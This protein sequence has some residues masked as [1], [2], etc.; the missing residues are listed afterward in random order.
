ME[1]FDDSL[2]P[3]TEALQSW[4]GIDGA[5]TPLGGCALSSLPLGAVDDMEGVAASSTGEGLPTYRATS[6]SAGRVPGLPSPSYDDKF[7]RSPASGKTNGFV[8]A[9]MTMS[10]QEPSLLSAEQQALEDLLME[11]AIDDAMRLHHERNEISHSRYATAIR[12]G[13]LLEAVELDDVRRGSIP[14]LEGTGQ[15]YPTWIRA[16][17][18]LHKEIPEINAETEALEAAATAAELERVKDA[19]YE[20]VEKAARLLAEVDPQAGIATEDFI[21][22][23]QTSLEELFG[24]DEGGTLLPGADVLAWDFE[25]GDS[26]EELAASALASMKMESGQ[27]D[28]VAVVARKLAPEWDAAAAAGR[29]ERNFS[30]DD[31]KMKRGGET[32]SEIV[33]ESTGA[34]TGSEL[35]ESSNDMEEDDEN[36]EARVGKDIDKRQ[37]EDE[38]FGGEDIEDIKEIYTMTDDEDGDYHALGFLEGALSEDDGGDSGRGKY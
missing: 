22:D 15:K 38:E 25:L 4:D 16:A 27:D 14:L 11:R 17:D 9:P 2:F 23:D 28:I 1:G 37:D 26:A 20:E 30:T 12:F 33:N 24:D 31:Y 19:I 35:E 10:T 34:A 21:S 6:R 32:A 8:M 3:N 29:A 36:E 5:S 13:E 18:V 7:D